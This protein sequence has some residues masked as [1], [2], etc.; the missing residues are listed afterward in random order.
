[1]TKELQ[2]ASLLELHQLLASKKI[3]SRELTKG[4]MDEI[5]KRD[6]RYGSFLTVLRE[7]ALQQAD[8]ADRRLKIGSDVTP[9]TGLPIALKDVILSKGSR[10]TAGSKILKDFVAPYDS[11]VVSR[12]RAA[13]AVF[14]GKTN[15]DEFAMGSSNENSSYGPVKNPWNLSCV[16]GGSSGGSAAAIAAREIPAALGT[17]TGGSIRQPAALCGIVGMK[18]TYGRVSRYGIVAFASS[19]DQVGPMAKRVEDCALLL[20]TIG[21]HD[22]LDSTSAQVPLGSYRDELQQPIRGLKI[23]VPKE[24]LPAALSAEVRANFTA[25]LK[26]LE[27]LGARVEEISLP[28]TDYAIATYYILATAEA[29]ANL[30]RYDGVRYT[31]RSSQARSVKEL[32]TK[33]RTEGFGA[34]VRRRIILGTFV[35]SS[36]YYDAYYQKGQQVRTLI[37][38]DFTDAFARVDLIATPTTPTPAFPIGSKTADPL[39]MY[40]SDI[41]TVSVPIAGLPGISVPSG[42][43]SSDLP[44]GLQ[45]IGKPFDETTILRAANAYE[46]ETRFYERR[47]PP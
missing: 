20:E 15:C 13:G 22:P 17:D 42:F 25:A 26:E 2:D 7:P 44:L 10:T 18:P 12:L 41:F 29:S 19:L 11:T 28:H 1:M 37:R 46:K 39:E 30:A 24:Y 31:H 40:L 47:P 35:L 14:V 36:G 32:I 43:T 5:Q 21:G 8:E 3:S 4:F 34:E 45:L 16:P 33:S 23:G 9:L 27:K 38:K 6:E